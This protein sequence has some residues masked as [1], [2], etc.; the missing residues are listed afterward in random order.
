MTND[1]DYELWAAMMADDESPAPVAPTP[2][3][4][5][6][7]EPELPITPIAPA[8]V[9]FEPVIVPE[10]VYVE[11]VVFPEP[12]VI[13]EPV[14][15]IEVSIETLPEVIAEDESDEEEPAFPTALFKEPQTNSITIPE[16]PDALS[17]AIVTDS[18]EVLKTGAIDIPL[19][20]NTG[21]IP[22][23]T[24]TVEAVDEDAINADM[25]NETTGGIPP[26]RARS[27][28]NSNARVGVLPIK[29]RRSEGQTVLLATT[30]ILL[31]TMGAA[32]LALYMLEIIK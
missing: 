8:P 3:T 5:A 21:S 2:V 17:S 13:P 6:E 16:I 32:I 19:L 20:N 24:D 31:V 25:G 14:F 23:I 10:P 26:I 11:P 12:V 18:G 29:N 1:A 15:P 30:S 9:V 27:V 4:V 7:P 22:I 28:M